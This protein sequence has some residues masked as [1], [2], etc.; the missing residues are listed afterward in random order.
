MVF[1]GV[2]KAILALLG[3]ISS[4][5]AVLQQTYLFSGPSQSSL[6]PIVTEAGTH[7]CIF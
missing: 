5:I 6:L 7:I 3:L 2:R 1:P 4:L